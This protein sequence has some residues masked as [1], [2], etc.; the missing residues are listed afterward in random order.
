MGSW[1]IALLAGGGW[2]DSSCCGS[3]SRV[4]A[5]G[6]GSV[7]ADIGRRGACEPLNPR[8]VVS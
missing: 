5:F 1:S 3:R 8:L 4:G 7:D 6:R 2:G